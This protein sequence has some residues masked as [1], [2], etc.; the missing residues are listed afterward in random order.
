[1]CVS[2][3]FSTLLAWSKV[4]SK[5]L[6]SSLFY[7]WSPIG[8]FHSALRTWPAALLR[9]VS[10]LDLNWLPREIARDKIITIFDCQQMSITTVEITTT[11]ETTVKPQPNYVWLT[12]FHPSFVCKRFFL[13]LSYCW[14]IHLTV[15]LKPGEQVMP[16][17][18]FSLLAVFRLQGT[19]D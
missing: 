1:M 2:I 9:R 14:Y 3:L 12:F 17:A 13:V 8:I 16:S 15:Q 19:F 10:V 5:K 18:I 6:P 7:L 4:V 11:W